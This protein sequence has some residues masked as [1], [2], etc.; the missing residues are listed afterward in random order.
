MTAYAVA[1]TLLALAILGGC[2]PKSAETKPT[3]DREEELSLCIPAQ[4][5]LPDGPDSLDT[6]GGDPRVE[7]EATGF[8]RV[9][10]ICDRWWFVTPTGHP[11]PS[12]GVN[13]T[14][15]VGS[16]SGVTGRS[17]YEE[18]VNEK[19]E[20]KE[21][22]AVATA[23]RLRSWGFNTA[24][25]WS[26]TDRLLPHIAVT[27]N[28]YLAGNDWLT[29]EVSDWY[30]PAWEAE[31]QQIVEEKVRPYL[32]EPNILG[33]YLDN[34]IRW[35]RDWRG[36]DTLLQLYLSLP[37]EAP[38]KVAAVD[39][40]LGRVGDTDAVNV[41]LNTAFS[42][43]EEMLAATE[44]WETLDADSSELETDLTSEWVSQCA[45]RYYST[46]VAGIRAVDPDH[47]VLGNREVASMTRPEVAA[48]AG[49]HLDVMSANNYVFVEGIAEAAMAMSGGLS[50]EDRLAALH[51]ETNLPILITEMG[52]RAA[53]AVPP[54]SWPPIYPT[55]DT[56]AE[57][58]DAFEAYVLDH[59]TAPWI[60]GY[61]WFEW[62]DQPADGRFDGEDNNWGVVDE[63]DEVY[64]IVTERMTRINAEIWG[65]L[66]VPRSP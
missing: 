19:Y 10:Q 42:S 22:W 40:L 34:E 41:A 17:I 54:S 32:D 29:G 23:D 52:F 44:G 63:R 12:Y 56:Q 57:R 26:D 45:E 65:Y 61:H 46:T 43:R 15:T 47:L 38:G 3:E 49:R 50:P 55:Y 2:T 66:E 27:P 20:S 11:M 28:L 58:A 60:V 30:D 37:A 31:V 48:A 51:Q 62:A 53:D 16:V 1:G 64:P 9:E 35:G 33:W 25:S 8:F 5:A 6:H 36:Q 18:T 24:G 14:Q 7:L 4:G 21:A 13:S 59:Q 39:F